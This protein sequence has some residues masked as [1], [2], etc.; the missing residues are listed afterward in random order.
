MANKNHNNIELRR[1]V[2]YKQFFADEQSI[3]IDTVL[4]QYDRAV[5]IR[6]AIVLSCHYGNMSF[7]DKS[8]TLFSSE[9][10]KYIDE[11]NERF[12]SFY[13]KNGIPQG[14]QVEVST[15]RTA[16]ELWRHIFSIK[17]EE[18]EGIIKAEDEEYS[19]FKVLL[20]L[21]EQ[22]VEFTHSGKDYRLDELLFLN[23]FVTNDTNN[24]DFQQ[25]IQPQLYYVFHLAQLCEQNDVMRK[26]S[27]V[28][29][30][31]W[32]IT[33][34]KQYVATLM[35]L[36]N[37]TEDYRKSQ[38]GGVP[39][40]QLHKLKLNDE[41]GLFSE[42]LVDALSIDED[43]YI[44]YE[45]S[46]NRSIQNIDYRIFRSKPFVRFKNKCDYAVINNQLL[47]E[48]IFN[49]L[50]FDFLPLIN[51]GK[52]SVG[53]F[54]YNKELIEK[55]LFRTTVFNCIP[56]NQF[57]F[58]PRDNALGKETNNEPDFYSRRGSDLLIFEC[59]AIKMNGVIRDDG[60]YQRL[61]NELHEKIVLK[62]R[63]LD[64]SRK[65][66]KGVPEPIGIG[67]LLHHIEAI[68]R[69]EFQWDASIPD[70]VTYY[71]VIV[72]E[73]V[74]I[75]QPGLLS[76]LNKWFNEELAKKKELSHIACGC[77]PVMAVSINT[78]YLYDNLLKRRGITR[79]VDEFVRSHSD[80]DK[81]G[82]TVLHADANFD[83]YLRINPFQKSNKLGKWLTN[84]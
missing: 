68:D 13:R 36:A 83:A 23:Q 11:L 2:E 54:D 44:P 43:E 56:S 76:I 49:S 82:N 8:R 21:N 32:G 80:V 17:A 1:I 27:E 35:Y 47:C 41:T 16:L 48:R 29:F 73:D 50:Y 19:L 39:I 62:T 34:W 42:T 59:K 15:F 25:A 26:A 22:I 31:R 28:L 81:D 18:Y 79:V 60:D 74:R 37:Q 75:L 40:I 5:L 7:P 52:T 45:D 3:D 33:S 30:E 6:M 4:R 69:D 64:P 71:P 67:Q 55:N 20:A 70:E 24:F 57:T 78:L 53:F 58:P 51:G 84:K 9:S 46:E 10:Q 14:S 63:N 72:F 66:H 65:Q 38:Q 77:Q 61:L 12:K